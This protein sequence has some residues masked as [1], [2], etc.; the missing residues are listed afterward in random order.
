MLNPRFIPT[1]A[2]N[3]ARNGNARQDEPVHPHRRGEH[4][5]GNKP[6]RPK[7]GSS[8]QTR[9]T[10]KTNRRWIAALRFIPTDAGNTKIVLIP[11]TLFPVH[12]HRRGEHLMSCSRTLMPRGSS[13]QTRGTRATAKPYPS[14]YRFIPTDAGNTH[15][16]YPTPPLNTVHPHRRGEHGSTLAGRLAYTGSSPQTR[17]TLQFW[18]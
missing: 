7:S 9:G 1:D 15:C 4:L 11:V 12:P 18:L 6:L 3:T 8:P 10:R 16:H 13:P 17:G 5:K 2:G 14:S